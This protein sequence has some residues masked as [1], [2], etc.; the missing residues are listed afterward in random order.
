M[1]DQ[2]TL[3]RIRKI[4]RDGKTKPM[5]IDPQHPKAET[6]PNEEDIADLIRWGWWGQKKVDGYRC[7][8]HIT[9]KG[10][11]T[12]YT[13]QGNIHTRA[14]P[15]ILTEQLLRHLKPAVGV[16]V[17]ESEWQRQQEKIY[18][19]DVLK[20]EDKLLEKKNFAERHQILRKDLFFIEPNIEFLPIYK[21]VRQCMQILKKDEEWI[22]GLV[23]KLPHNP[24]WQNDAIQR[25]R[26]K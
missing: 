14:V 10:E 13:R 8:I 15:A 4:N 2:N 19:F 12:Y 5:F 6:P 17:F 23:F 20:L 24:G 26:I 11:I 25:C 3:K 21:S 16:S 9:A 1:L 22:E 7:Q 18:L